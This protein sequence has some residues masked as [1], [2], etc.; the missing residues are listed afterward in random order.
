PERS[1]C[2]CSRRTRSITDIR[3]R[4]RATGNSTSGCCGSSSTSGLPPARR[5][6]RLAR[7]SENR[8]V[9]DLPLGDERRPPTAIDPELDEPADADPAPDRAG[10]ARGGTQEVVE[11]RA[12][13]ALVGLVAEVPS[14]GPQRMGTEQLRPLAR[15][16]R[17]VLEQIEPD[18][19][20]GAENRGALGARVLVQ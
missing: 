5:A 3:R 11:H 15:E 16:Q 13:P 14:V 1:G 17:R 4:P 8:D 19:R 10:G 7:R 18:Q 12:P 9:H 6:E 20:L 2:T